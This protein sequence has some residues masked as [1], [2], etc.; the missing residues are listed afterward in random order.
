LRW[1][2]LVSIRRAT[3]A[4]KRGRLDHLSCRFCNA[5]SRRPFAIV[6]WPWPLI[7]PVCGT[8]SIRGGHGTG[9]VLHDTTVVTQDSK[10]FVYVLQ[11]MSQPNR[12]FV[13]SAA[14]VPM[15]LAA[16]NA[17]HSPLTASCRPWR[18]VA[19]VQF[20]TESEAARFEKF[21]KTGAGRALARDYFSRVDPR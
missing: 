15:R 9:R 18:L 12:Q 20:G 4:L 8:S 21:L 6:Q 10:R 7:S 14:N 5:V 11:S 3:R 16:H 1:R 19:V 17:G 13:E 2:T